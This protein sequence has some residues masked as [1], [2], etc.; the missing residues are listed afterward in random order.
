M[1]DETFWEKIVDILSVVY[2]NEINKQSLMK[3]L[4]TDT[5]KFFEK[6]KTLYDLYSNMKTSLDSEKNAIRRHWNKR[7][8]ELEIFVGNVNDLWSGL[9]AI[10]N[11]FPDDF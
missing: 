3:L 7:E 1:A 5:D 4:N 11:S 2:D 9:N 6:I 8:T 10:T